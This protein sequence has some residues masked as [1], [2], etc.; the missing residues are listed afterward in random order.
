MP[1]YRYCCDNDQCDFEDDELRSIDTRDLVRGCEH[2]ATGRLIRDHTPTTP[3]V[4]ITESKTLNLPNRAPVTKTRTRVLG[5]D[6]GRI[7]VD[8][9]ARVQNDLEEKYGADMDRTE[10]KERDKKAKIRE[11]IRKSKMNTQKH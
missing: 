2:C 6:T 7:R 5:S 11:A 8:K 1:I 4:T 9:L 10:Q 3:M